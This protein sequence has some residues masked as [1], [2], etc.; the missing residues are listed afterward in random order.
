MLDPHPFAVFHRV[1]TWF[2]QRGQDSRCCMPGIWAATR[3]FWPCGE[4]WGACWNSNLKHVEGTLQARNRRFLLSEG[5]RRFGGLKN[6]LA[7]LCILR[8]SHEHLRFSLNKTFDSKILQVCPPSP[9]S[10]PEATGP[11]HGRG[12]IASNCD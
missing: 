9:A 5:F 7:P 8:S 3:F 11:S 4:M 2:I 10:W 6:R 1:F 12:R